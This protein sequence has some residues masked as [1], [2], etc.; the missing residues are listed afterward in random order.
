MY[1]RIA[2]E[3][4]EIVVVDVESIKGNSFEIYIQDK[5]KQSYKQCSVLFLLPESIDSWLEEEFNKAIVACAQRYGC[6][7][8]E[9]L[10][11]LSGRIKFGTSNSSEINNLTSQGINIEIPIVHENKTAVNTKPT[12]LIVD[13]DNDSLFTIGE[14]VKELNY[15]TMFAHNGIECLLTLKHVEPDLIL[16][17]IMMPQMDGF[18]TIKRIRAEERYAHLPVLALTA[19]AML[20]NKNVIEKN[21]FNDLITKPVNSK[22]LA[23]KIK[24]NLIMKVNEL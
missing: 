7:I 1:N 9:M 2:T 3:I 24:S 6:N 14:I 12:I 11:L 20:D 17:D 22:I 18:E 10:K 8:L 13:D 4:P 23:S 15:E 19:Y 5:I 16:L 21:G